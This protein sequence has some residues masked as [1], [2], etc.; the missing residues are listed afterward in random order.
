M[1][2]KGYAQPTRR[3]PEGLYMVRHEW[4]Q[5]AACSGAETDLFFTK[6]Q[7][8]QAMQ[9]CWRCPVSTECAEY[10]HAN[11]E[12]GVWGGLT[13][14]QRAR[15]HRLMPALP[16]PNTDEAELAERILSLHRSGVSYTQIRKQTGVHTRNI[17]RILS[18][19]ESL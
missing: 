18:R 15:G 11:G 3:D 6:N 7:T 8:L 16:E 10:A 1:T 12:Q 4:M 19:R 9:Y 5:H 13:D 14:T 17:F 2:R